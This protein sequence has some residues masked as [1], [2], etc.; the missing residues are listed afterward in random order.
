[1]KLL[2]PVRE[3]IRS[4]PDPFGTLMMPI[5]MSKPSAI[6][7]LNKDD[8]LQTMESVLQS[9]EDLSISDGFD[10]NI[11]VINVPKGSGGFE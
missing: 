5:L 8:V 1:M 7:Q 11:D 2:V 3:V 10:I 9:H 4:R 6:H